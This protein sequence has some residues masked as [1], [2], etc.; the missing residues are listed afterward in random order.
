MTKIF[1]FTL[2][3][4]ISLSTFAQSRSEMKFLK[5]ENAHLKDVKMNLEEE[6][7]DLKQAEKKVTKTED[8]LKSIIKDL[9]TQKSSLSKEVENL[10]KGNKSLQAKTQEIAILTK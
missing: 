2:L 6:I 8:S 5:D 1:T 9:D 4:L 7:Y 3:L 10:K